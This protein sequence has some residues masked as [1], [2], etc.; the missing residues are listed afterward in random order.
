V[1]ETRAKKLY[2]E[3]WNVEDKGLE[4]K[5]ACFSDTF[6]DFIKYS[7]LS[8]HRQTRARGLFNRYWSPYFRNIQIHKID[9]KMYQE[10]LEWRINY[11]E[12]V[13]LKEL[14]A[15]GDKVYH[16]K[17]IPTE[18]TLKSEKQLFKQFLY[19][20]DTKRLIKVVPSLRIN[21]KALLGD[22]FT[23][24]R[25]KSKAL[26]RS[27]ERRI[28]NKLRQYALTDGQKDKNKMRAYGRARF[29]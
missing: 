12:N 24:K 29:Y 28:Q 1:A 26:T 11:W 9:T 19:W 22:K 17:K 14:Q 7:G 27:Q 5:D 25:Q 6:P 20:C 23:D 3:M 16:I 15:A 18:T 10:F 13:D 4:F 2:M 21:F 8:T